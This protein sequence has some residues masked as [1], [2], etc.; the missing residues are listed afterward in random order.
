M[1]IRWVN[2]GKAV[3]IVSGMK[4]L[5]YTRFRG[6][7]YTVFLYAFCFLCNISEVQ[8]HIMID[9]MSEFSFFLIASEIMVPLNQPYHR[10]DEA[11]YWCYSCPQRQWG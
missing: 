11:P 5:L 1:K 2:T 3:D 6:T 7:H 9:S 10:F 4:Q 8:R